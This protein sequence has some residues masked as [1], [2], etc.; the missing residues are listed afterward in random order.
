MGQSNNISLG[1]HEDALQQDKHKD[2]KPTTLSCRALI[3]VNDLISFVEAPGDHGK[4]C[5]AAPLTGIQRVVLDQISII[6]NMHHS[7]IISHL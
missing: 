1:T 3:P 2:W 5:A 6:T 4:P 7:L